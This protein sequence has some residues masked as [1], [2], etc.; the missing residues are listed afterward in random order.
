M[1]G[2]AMAIIACF[3]DDRSGLRVALQLFISFTACLAEPLA[4]ADARRSK[5]L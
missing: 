5:S 4:P 3:S 1:K 2:A